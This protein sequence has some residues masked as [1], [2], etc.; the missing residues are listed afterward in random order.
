MACSYIASNPIPEGEGEKYIYMEFKNKGSKDIPIYYIYPDVTSSFVSRT[1]DYRNPNPSIWRTKFVDDTFNA[2]VSYDPEW[3]QTSMQAPANQFGYQPVLKPGEVLWAIPSIQQLPIGQ[4][5]GASEVV[6]ELTVLQ[7]VLLSFG[8]GIITAPSSCQAGLTIQK[9]AEKNASER[10]L[11]HGQD[12]NN[13]I[14]VQPG[15]TFEAS[16]AWKNDGGNLSLEWTPEKYDAVDVVGFRKLWGKETHWALPQKTGLKKVAEFTGTFTAPQKPGTYPFVFS[17]YNKE[18]KKRFGDF[19]IRYI[20]VKNPPPP[21]VNSPSQ[22]KISSV[23]IPTYHSLSLGN[24]LISRGKWAPSVFSYDIENLGPTDIVASTVKIQAGNVEAFDE[25]GIPFAKK[26]YDV[27][28]TLVPP[29]LRYG[30]KGILTLDSSIGSFRILVRGIPA[31]NRTML[32]QPG[33]CNNRAYYQCEPVAPYWC[34]YSC[35]APAIEA[36]QLTSAWL[37]NRGF[38]GGTLFRLAEAQPNFAVY[39]GAFAYDLHKYFFLFDDRRTGL[40]EP[41]LPWP[42][43]PPPA[44]ILTGLTSRFDYY[45]I[46]GWYPALFSWE[47]ADTCSAGTGSPIIVPSGGTYTPNLKAGPRKAFHYF[48]FGNDIY[49]T[50]G[51]VASLQAPAISEVSKEYAQYIEYTERDRANE[52]GAYKPGS[53][54]GPEK[55]TLN[56]IIVAKDGDAADCSVSAPSWVPYGSTFPITF[57]L[58]NIGTQTWDSRYYVADQ[59]APHQLKVTQ[60]QAL[61]GKVAPGGK[62]VFTVQATAPKENT[63]IHGKWALKRVAKGASVGGSLAKVCGF[64]IAVGE[65]KYKDA[66]CTASVNTNRVAPGGTFTFQ[67]KVTNTGTLPWL[68][69]EVPWFPNEQWLHDNWAYEHRSYNSPTVIHHS[70]AVQPGDQVLF[71]SE[72]KAPNRP[73][74]YELSWNMFDNAARKGSGEIGSFG[75]ECKASVQ[76]MSYNDASCT[77]TAP[78]RVRP[79]GKFAFTMNLKNMG[80]TV[81]SLPAYYLADLQWQQRQ[82][83]SAVTAAHSGAIVPGASSTVVVELTAPSQAGSYSLV[84]QMLENGKEY[85]GELCSASVQVDPDAPLSSSSASSSTSSG[86]SVSVGSSS[87]S[88]FASGALLSS[89]SASPVSSSIP[90]SVATSSASGGDESSN[91]ASSASSVPVPVCGNGLLEKGEECD[92]G[93]ANGGAPDATCRGNCRLPFC[94]DGVIDAAKGEQCDDGNGKPGDGCGRTCVVERCGDGVVTRS[95]GEA[96]DDGNTSDTEGPCRADCKAYGY[97]GDGFVQAPETCDDGNMLGNDSCSPDCT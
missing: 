82:A 37:R 91:P 75:Q 40:R 6:P 29:I 88:S 24:T 72:L 34:Y 3:Y 51:S 56:P 55:C 78:Q 17:M 52:L 41:K 9:S 13:V 67:S 57:T 33:K 19:C 95:I 61:S 79:G 11:I 90:S 63:I 15:D 30:E 44:G 46:N 23:Y 70:S 16:C 14:T 94:G 35:S 64:D 1:D 73:G 97:C 74:T 38:M 31:L 28:F 92:G 5:R 25:R 58:T 89:S 62:A 32:D 12:L 27:P 86:A 4:L 84:W 48:A 87:L 26:G 39:L 36:Q 45:A 53:V 76:V 47:A 59:R 77:A 80:N 69:N 54:T 71:Q 96:C 21:A 60:S 85:F 65:D 68:P 22:L 66:I 93:L 20:D 2:L 49:T 10:A 18:T 83:Y 8:A 42:T 81:W 43:N 7:S 50:N